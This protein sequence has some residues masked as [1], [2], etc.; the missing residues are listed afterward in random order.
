[1]AKTVIKRM[2]VFS[3]A[4][5]QALICTVLGLIIGVLYGL[6]FIIF[7]AALMSQQGASGASGVVIG[8]VIMVTAP[9]MYGIFG[10]I[11]GLIVGFI[12]N[13]AAGFVGGIELD[14]ESATPDYSAPPPPSQA[15][16]S[17]NPFQ[18]EKQRY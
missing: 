17:S 2:G 15:W 16:S 1:M 14:L 13:V 4:K 8:L 18:A 5:I 6:I 7:G 3:V 9:I 11:S 12:Y 10:F